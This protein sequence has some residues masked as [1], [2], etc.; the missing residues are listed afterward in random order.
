MPLARNCVVND[1][2]MHF[3]LI[4]TFVS[5]FSENYDH[6][7][8]QDLGWNWSEDF[9]RARRFQSLPI[10]TGVDLVATSTLQS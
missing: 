2:L 5:Y 4:D 7:F 3:A 8:T 10:V 9:L 1:S 6:H